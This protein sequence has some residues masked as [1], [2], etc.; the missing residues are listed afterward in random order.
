MPKCFNFLFFDCEIFIIISMGRSGIPP[1]NPPHT[2]GCI[3]SVTTIDNNTFGIIIW[4]IEPRETQI[5]LIWKWKHSERERE[6][7]KDYPIVRFSSKV[8]NGGVGKQ[9]VGDGAGKVS[10]PSQEGQAAGRRI[11]RAC[12]LPSFV[13]LSR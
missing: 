7:C 6:R 8:L 13:F 9:G 11:Y 4:G 1:H 10:K 12:C 3:A 5:R 2:F